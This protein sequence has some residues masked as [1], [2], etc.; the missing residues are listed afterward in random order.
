VPQVE[1]RTLSPDP[2]DQRR[3]R[4]VRR[5]P[6]VSTDGYVLTDLDDGPGP[7]TLYSTKATGSPGNQLEVTVGWRIWLKGWEMGDLE[8]AQQGVG[9]PGV[10]GGRGQLTEDPAAEGEVTDE[11]EVISAVPF[12]AFTFTMG[13]LRPRVPPFVSVT[14]VRHVIISDLN[15]LK[16]NLTP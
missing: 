3:R 7:Q 15:S 2:M 6:G 1:L 8:A 14:I 12:M 5:R 13:G 11:E 10:C 16:K 9:H 4:G